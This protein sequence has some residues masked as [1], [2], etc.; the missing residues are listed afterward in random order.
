M[1]LWDRAKA[2]PKLPPTLVLPSEFAIA[3]ATATV[4][5]RRRRRRRRLTIVIINNDAV[6][7]WAHKQGR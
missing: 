7:S 1:D 5:R 4:R 3:T 6:A 2:T